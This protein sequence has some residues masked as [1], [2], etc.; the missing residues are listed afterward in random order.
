MNKKLI[1]FIPIFV[2]MCVILF[3]QT[4]FLPAY[5]FNMSPWPTFMH[6]YSHTGLSQFTGAQSNT[7]SWQ[8]NVKNGTSA[9]VIGQNNIMYFGSLGNLVALDR[10]HA[11]KFK[12]NVGG[13]VDPPSIGSDGT[14]YFENGGETIF[15]A[16]PNGIIKWNYQSNATV[17]IPAIDVYDRIYFG[18]GNFLESISPDGKLFWKY[19][20]N[21]LVS[22]PSIGP[23]GTIYIGD[24]D[25][26][27][28][29]LDSS[30]NLKWSFNAKGITTLGSISP[31][32]TIYFCD[33]YNYLYAVNQDGTLKWSFQSSNSGTP[34]SIGPD[35]TVFLQ[36]GTGLVVLN[37]DGTKKWN[38]HPVNVTIQSI[39]VDK[40]GTIYAG[41]FENYLYALDSSGNVKW[42]FRADG[43]VSQP[44]IGSDGTIYFNSGKGVIYALGQQAIP[45]F[46]IPILLV[47]VSFVII[48]ALPRVFRVQIPF[49]NDKNN[50]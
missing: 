38:Y 32:N 49:L 2:V 45:E 33:S 29:A 4:F 24:S 27:F 13:I 1:H 37:S 17:T 35:N 3:A 28:Y 47:I 43:G 46:P 18:S 23:D 31:Q 39:S 11:V 36:N 6:D 50:L 21:G 25:H 22:M 20:T 34:P 12:I 26:N 44:A 40:D 14:L 8:F 19:H 9:L 15:A 42:N 10:D 5:G 30:G 16:S 48:L 7:T 41:S